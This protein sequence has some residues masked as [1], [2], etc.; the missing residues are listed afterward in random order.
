MSCIEPDPNQ[1]RKDRGELTD[2]ATSI[3]EHGVLNPIIVEALGPDRYRILAGERRF[4]ACQ[5]LKLETVPCI[6][7]TVAEHSRLVLQLIENLHRKDLHPVEEAQ[8]FKRLM[9]EF[10]LTQR[11]LARRV[12]KSLAAVNQSLRILDLKPELL[13]DVQTSEHATKSLLL[14]IVKEP[15]PEQQRAFWQKAQA[16]QMT[17]RQA[18]AEKRPAP[19]AKQ[20]SAVCKISLAAAELVIRFREGEGTPERVLAVLQEALLQSHPPS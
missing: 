4:A 2:L 20:C 14:E 6:L 15:N 17:V 1:P 8:A 10:N 16:V 13:A 3:R 5:I 11:D 9:D 7:R 19:K 18:R 12:G